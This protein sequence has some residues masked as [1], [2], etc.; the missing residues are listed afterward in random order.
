V[1]L[2]GRPDTDPV[3]LELVPAG[4]EPSGWRCST[5]GCPGQLGLMTPP[6]VHPQ[7]FAFRRA[8]CPECGLRWWVESPDG[9]VVT[10]AKRARGRVARMRDG[11]LRQRYA[12]IRAL[13]IGAVGAGVGAVAAYLATRAW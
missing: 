12:I 13:Q 2:M 11:V 8:E 3:P 10:A 9:R 5:L 4:R 7:L 1:T 6:V